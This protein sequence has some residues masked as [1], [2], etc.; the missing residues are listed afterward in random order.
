M[1]GHLTNTILLKQGVPQGDI[2]SPFVFIIAVEILLIKVSSS[3]NIQGIPLGNKECRALAY[4]DD[5]SFGILR[6]ERSLRACMK[7]I[8]QFKSLSGL[9][10][11]LDK[12]KVIPIG[13]ITNPKTKMCP[14]IPLEWTDKF[15]LLGIEIDNQLLQLDLNFDRI[16]LKTE[17]IISD[18]KARKLP[19][20]GR[21]A[22]SKA[23]LIS[24]YTYISSILFLTPTQIAAAQ[25]QINNFILGISSQNK[26]WISNDRLYLPISKGGLGC[27]ELGSFFDGLKISWMRRYI[28]EGYQDHWADILDNSLHITPPQR[29]NV[30]EWGDQ[31]FNNPIKN[32]KSPFLKQLLKTMQK[33]VNLHVTDPETGDN[34]FACQP[35]FNNS[36]LKFKK[37]GDR[38]K[39]C[40]SQG[41]FGLPAKFHPKIS[42]VFNL[43]EFI[44]Y[45][46]FTE[47]CF[48]ANNKVPT[49]NSYLSLKH[50]LNT[51]FGHKKSTLNPSKI[52]PRNR[53][54]MPPLGTLLPP[55]EKNPKNLETSYLNPT[56]N[57]Q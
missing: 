25:T 22:I 7:Y 49:E 21:I 32:C 36:H 24:Q 37:Y 10:A 39:K 2:I 51:L 30:L 47:L 50:H 12:T 4:A 23:L 46:K 3:K 28:V 31:D 11:N 29:A 34:T 20:E 38:T 53:E 40:F 18:W 16:F 27:M 45:D 52:K 9:S 33:L 56:I 1:G 17:T 57:F 13:P 48:K 44:S 26:K 43:G 14:D 19:I 15:T 54:H 55:K 35:I 8:E 41:Y 6:E 5:T 42:D